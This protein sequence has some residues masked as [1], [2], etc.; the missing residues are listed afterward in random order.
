MFSNLVSLLLRFSENPFYKKWL[1][2]KIIHEG[3]QT[4]GE[5]KKQS[6]R[7]HAP[8]TTK[9]RSLGYKN[10]VRGS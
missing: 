3:I 2:E 8:I 10:S 5:K 9:F 4:P 7:T 6:A 1:G